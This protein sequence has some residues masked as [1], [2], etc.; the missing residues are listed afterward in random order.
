M[1]ETS[2]APRSAIAA[3]ER[4]LLRLSMIDGAA[5]ARGSEVRVERQWT[6]FIHAA[7]A[8]NVDTR[9]SPALQ[10]H[11]LVT[12]PFVAARDRQRS[13]PRFDDR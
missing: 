2:Q 9:L 10:E 13:A 6:L 12:G 8:Q 7:I 3:I 1:N 5:P 4:G 11:A